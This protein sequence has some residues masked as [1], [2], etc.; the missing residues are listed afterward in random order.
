M[1][2]L[3]VDPPLI[4]VG[5]CHAPEPFT[6]SWGVTNN[7]DTDEEYECTLSVS[8]DR[9]GSGRVLVET[10]GT[11]RAGAV[12]PASFTYSPEAPGKVTFTLSITGDGS[13]SI[14]V[15]CTGDPSIPIA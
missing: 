9:A 15:I 1:A 3:A 11:I 2:N 4:A 8:D 6:L 14:E 7:G 13:Q 10:G 12:S 5:A